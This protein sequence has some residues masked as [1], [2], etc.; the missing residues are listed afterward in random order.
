MS[1]RTMDEIREQ[2]R[3]RYAAA[4]TGARGGG[5]CCGPS[6]GL[7]DAQGTQVFGDA[8]YAEGEAAGAPAAAVQAS[9]GCGVPTA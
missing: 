4:A 8:L 3:D 1:S 6:D 5:G 7:T 2:V 9:L